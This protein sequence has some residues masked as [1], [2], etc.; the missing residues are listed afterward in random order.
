[1]TSITLPEL[2]GLLAGAGATAS[3]SECHGALCGALCVHDSYS[4][5][6]WLQDLAPNQPL[7][8]EEERF[9]TLIQDTRASLYSD[10]MSFQP[11]LPDDDVPM[12]ARTEAL[13]DWCEGFLYGLS[14]GA[15][16]RHSRTSGDVEEVL[17]DFAEISRAAPD[18][19]DSEEENEAAYAELVEFVRVGVQLVHDELADLREADG[20]GQAS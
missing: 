18:E 2:A 15:L 1:M 14:T 9:A 13:A 4:A 11:L 6:R 19:A 10:Q 20:A 3:A 16:G 17:R 5:D 8:A 7:R 12:A